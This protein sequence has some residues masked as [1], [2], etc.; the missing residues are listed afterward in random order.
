VLCGLGL[1]VLQMQVTAK[2]AAM[3]VLGL[4]GDSPVLLQGTHGLPPSSRT[5]LPPY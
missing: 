2:M 1:Y 4:P 3:A 5:S